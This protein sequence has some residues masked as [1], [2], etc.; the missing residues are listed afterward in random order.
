[1]L[2]LDQWLAVWGL[3]TGLLGIVAAYVFYLK[4]KK[5]PA[6]WYSIHP[7]RVHIVDK[8][9]AD[10]QGLEVRHNGVLLSD[11]NITATTV[12][13]GNRGNAPIRSADILESLVV[14]LPEGSEILEA[15]IVQVSRPVCGFILG[16]ISN[17]SR[18][19]SIRFNIAEK[20]DGAKVQIIH[21]GNP[22]AG[23]S[24]SGAFVGCT[25]SERDYET[26]SGPSRFMT[27]NGLQLAFIAAIL[28]GDLIAF[29]S[30]W[31]GAYTRTQ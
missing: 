25:L 24:V 18:E 3:L 27:Q 20:F 12:F 19:V 17:E 13:W 28:T 10:V 9:Q 1:M 5:E 30:R 4:S 21:R 2:S 29:H 6:P 11:R 23:I 31:G 26:I 8:S 14:G 16:P 7:L 22:D 15:R